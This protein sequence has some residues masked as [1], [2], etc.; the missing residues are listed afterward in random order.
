MCTNFNTT[1]AAQIKALTAY[2]EALTIYHNIKGGS[3]AALT[4]Y[5]VIEGM[6]TMLR[7]FGVTAADMHTAREWAYEA[8]LTQNKKA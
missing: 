3:Q 8:F 6:V 2:A 7:I 1:D 4:Q 5:H